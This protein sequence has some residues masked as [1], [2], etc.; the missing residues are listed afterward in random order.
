MPCA[1]WDLANV[2]Q[3]V[4]TEVPGNCGTSL[5]P[6]VDRSGPIE[7]L[8][9][10]SLAAYR[11][12]L[13][14]VGM[15]VNL[16]PLVGHG[17]IRIAALGHEERAPTPD[18]LATMQRLTEQ[19]MEEGAFG[20]STGLA[21]VPGV[22]AQEQ[23][24]IV[25]GSAATRL[26]WARDDVALADVVRRMTSLPCEAFRIPDRGVLRRGYVADLVVLDPDTVAPGSTYADPL[27]PPRGVSHVA[28]AGRVVV[29]DGH[30]TGQRP[31]RV[32]EPA[33]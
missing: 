16:A 20:M 32:L 5:F 9:F 15:V 7:G 4:T 23:E 31:G 29:G 8:A 12:A 3:G 13:D 10:A 22:F 28:V 19:A 11:A 27:L 33:T 18:E 24:L 2:L 17:T 26:S 14:D 21:L 25:P 30:A 1:S 6:F